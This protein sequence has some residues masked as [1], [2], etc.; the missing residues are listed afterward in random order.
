MTFR[1]D[2]MYIT[3]FNVILYVSFISTFSMI[4][5]DVIWGG[6]GAE[7]DPRPLEEAEMRSLMINAFTFYKNGATI[8]SVESIHTWSNMVLFMVLN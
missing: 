4:N 7:A 3:T 6:K 5:R 8:V 2:A 1:G